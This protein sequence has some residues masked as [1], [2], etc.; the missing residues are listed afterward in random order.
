LTITNHSLPNTTKVLC[1]SNDAH[2]AVD[3]IV[4][5]EGA[6]VGTRVTFEGYSGAPLPE[7]NP[8]KKILERLLPDL[9]TDASGAPCY[10]GVPFMTE[11][12][13]VTSTMPNSH[14]G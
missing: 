9:H 7:V 8:K 12:G 6:P 11:H 4:P 10:K 1:A 13:P 3:P 5:P 2:D 14:V